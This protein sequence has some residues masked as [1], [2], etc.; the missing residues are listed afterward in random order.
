VCWTSCEQIGICDVPVEVA[1]AGS[2]FVVDRRILTNL[3]VGELELPDFA[4]AQ[5]RAALSAGVTES[6]LAELGANGGVELGG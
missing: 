5:V 4:Q 6:A 1:K 2:R 3:K